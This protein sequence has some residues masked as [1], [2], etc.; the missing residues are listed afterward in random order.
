MSFVINHS[1]LSHL[2][3]Y[4]IFPQGGLAKLVFI[5]YDTVG[6]LL[7]P[8]DDVTDDDVERRLVSKVVSAS[9]NEKPLDEPLIKPV[10][11]TMKT[12]EVSYL[13]VLRLQIKIQT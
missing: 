6:E 2:S 4:I 11:F 1:F 10:I 7:I 9:L 13:V 5:N 3:F 12:H 8:E